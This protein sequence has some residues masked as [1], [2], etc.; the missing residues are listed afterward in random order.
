NLEASLDALLEHADCVALGPGLG[1]DETARRIVDHVVFGWQ[2]TKVVDADAI[3]LFKGRTE[4]L[5]RAKSD[6][7][8]TP[9]S[10][11]MARLLD[12][13]P[14]DVEANRFTMVTRCVE[15][16]EAVSL[17]KGY[18]TLIGAPGQRTVVNPT[19]TPALA[20][21]GSGDTLTGIIAG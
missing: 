3:T 10:G 4:S 17:L 15:M 11:E 2:G 12:T 14:S 19:G 1:L 16:T 7:I 9:H 5:K 6:V 18:R 21:G 20:T 8:L 13:A